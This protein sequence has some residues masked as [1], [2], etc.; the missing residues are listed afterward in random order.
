MVFRDWSKNITAEIHLIIW[1]V[2]IFILK[3]IPDF[4]NF[5]KIII[6]S[7]SVISFPSWHLR[8]YW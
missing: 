2:L 8:R 5:I 3:I 7:E 4:H 6:T 1:H